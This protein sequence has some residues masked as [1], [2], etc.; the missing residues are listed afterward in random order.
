MRLK[1]ETAVQGPTEQDFRLAERVQLSGRAC[2]LCMNKWDLVPK[3]TD[4]MMQVRPRVGVGDAEGALS[5]AK[6]SKGDAKMGDSKSSKGD[7]KSSLGDV[8]ISPA[9]HL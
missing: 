7:A 9:S 2:V 5:D 8:G 4:T 6:S 1:I 3:D